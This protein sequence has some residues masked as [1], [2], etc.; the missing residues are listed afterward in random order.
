MPRWAPV[1]VL[2]W[3][4]CPW[5]L[6][7]LRVSLLVF[8]RLLLP[9]LQLQLRLCLGLLRLPRLLL[10]LLQFLAGIAR[11]N[12]WAPTAAGI[13]CVARLTSLAGRRRLPSLRCPSTAADAGLAAAGRAVATWLAARAAAVAAPAWPLWLCNGCVPV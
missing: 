11:S 12:Q 6:P 7:L 4:S 13:V 10:L 2:R 1:L 8:L 5:L 3:S 9:A